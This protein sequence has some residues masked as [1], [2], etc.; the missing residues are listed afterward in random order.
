MSKRCIERTLEPGTEHECNGSRVVYPASRSAVRSAASEECAVILV[1]AAFVRAQPVVLRWLS[2]MTAET[3]IGVVGD[4]PDY[5]ET[6]ADACL[7]EPVTVPPVEALVQRVASRRAYIDAAERYYRAVT[8]G[9]GEHDLDPARTAA[10]EYAASLDAADRR[11]V[12][13]ATG[14]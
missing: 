9:T 6:L 1:D 11:A 14:G 12:L 3:M 2:T 10:D 4:A 5:L 13:D 8:D 7:D